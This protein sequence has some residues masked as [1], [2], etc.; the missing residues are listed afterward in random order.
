M[1]SSQINFQAQHVR[2]RTQPKQKSL[3]NRNKITN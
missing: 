1:D 3:H 2:V